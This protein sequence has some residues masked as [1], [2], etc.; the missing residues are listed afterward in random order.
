MMNVP[1]KHI[2]SKTTF[3]Y[4]CQ[5]PKRLWLN[6]YMPKEK[7]VLTDNQKAIFQQGTDIGLLAQQLFPNGVDATPS[8]K[9]DY[10]KAVAQTAAYIQQG[11]SIIYEAA[12]Q[13]EGVLVIL[14]ILV[15]RNNQWFAFEVKSSTKVKDTFIHDAALQYFVITHAGIDLKDISIIH[16]NNE[17]IRKGDL[18][19]N[20]LFQNTSIYNEVLQKQD[21]IDA[22]IAELKLVLNLPTPPVI[23]L[24]K[25]CYSPYT[26]DF[27]GYCS[28]GLP[29]EEIDFGESNLDKISLSN[30]INQ[31]QYPLYFMDFETWMSAIPECDGHWPYRQ[32]PFQF[33]LHIQLT[34][35]SNLEH[36]EYLAENTHSDLGIF[37]QKLIDALGEDGSILVYNK[38][39]ENARLNELKLDFPHLIESISR[40]QERLVDLMTPFRNKHLYM[41]EMQGS[42]SIKNVLPALVPEL[43]YANLNVNNGSDAS[44]IF[45]NLANE[46]DSAI[47]KQTREHLLEYCKLDT[48]AMVKILEKINTIIK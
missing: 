23:E 26:C 32:V 7:D 27:L 34:E 17:Y 29:Q 40:I 21:E 19:I 12:F 36:I 1:P 25:Q 30:F 37:I 39:F 31:L 10:P 42:Y 18:D 22:K 5:C 44:S 2:L 38:T 3:I 33:S 6:K 46:N 43:S 9:Y 16:L 35:K 20:L 15:K 47:V 13:H 45:Y 4:G 24:G 28:K 48:Y 8:F 41:P 11:K 14:D